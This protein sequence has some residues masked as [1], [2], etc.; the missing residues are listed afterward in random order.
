MRRNNIIIWD[1]VFDISK[2]GYGIAYGRDDNPNHRGEQD[3][4]RHPCAGTG[5]N[6]FSKNGGEVA[7]HSHSGFKQPIAQGSR[8]QNS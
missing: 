8:D 1:N 7:I 3:Q 5:A 4:K 2:G 6:Q